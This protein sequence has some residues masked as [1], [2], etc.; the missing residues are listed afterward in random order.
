MSSEERPPLL[1]IMERPRVGRPR[2]SVEEKIRRGTLQSKE[3]RYAGLPVRP[4]A[5]NGEGPRRTRTHDRVGRPRKSV[6]E[7]ISLGTFR[8]HREAQALAKEKKAKAERKAEY[9][10]LPASRFQCWYCR[11]RKPAEAGGVCCFAPATVN[12]KSRC[13]ICGGRCT[14]KRCAICRTLERER[15]P[16]HQG[17]CG[18]CKRPFEWRS[19]CADPAKGHQRRYCGR[20]CQL[21]ANAERQAARRKD[22][23]DKRELRRERDRIYGKLRIAKGWKAKKGRTRQICDRDGWECWI[24]RGA[25][26]SSLCNPHPMSG[27]I[28]HVLPLSKGGSDSDDNLRAAHLSCNC[29]RGNGSRV[30][31]AKRDNWVN[32]QPF[33]AAEAEARSAADIGRGEATARNISEEPSA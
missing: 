6:E 7:K 4:K 2:L 10:A 13:D 16:P 30:E 25:I 24:C 33:G 15:R 12:G 1:A 29:R 20:A 9:A 21:S 18:H 22:A 28:D 14:G 31:N 32:R 8:P 27:S 5:K 17:V 23:D 11:K 26:D 19:S 3:R